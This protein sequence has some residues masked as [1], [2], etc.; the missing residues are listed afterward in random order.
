M[1]FLEKL[2]PLPRWKHS[3]PS[4]RVAA[5]YEF[6]SADTEALHAVAREDADAR[7]RRASVSRLTEVSVLVEI[8]GSD[9]DEDVRAEAIR[10]LAGQAAEADGAGAALPILQSLVVLGRNREVVAIARSAA[11]VDIRA[12]AT[13]LLQDA[14]S[15]GSVSRHAEDTATRLRALAKI[16]SDDELV[17]VACKCDHTDAA[18]AA[19]ERLSDQEAVSAVSQR[20]RNKVALRR[21]RTRLREME[22]AARP[23]PSEPAVQMLLADRQRA[24][25]ITRRASVLVTV[26]LPD[27]AAAQLSE[28]RLA[29][30]EMQADVVDVDP[31]LLRSF[32]A[33]CEAAGEA[34]AER[35]RDQAAALDRTR[36]L[37]TEQSDRLAICEEI[38]RLAGPESM[39]RVAE[40]KAKW[41]MLP[42]MPSDYAASL[43]LRFQDVCREQDARER[44][45][46]LAE[47]A[48]SRLETLASELEHLSSSEQPVDETVVRWR[49]LRRD[50]ETLREF[51]DANPAAGERLTRAIEILE[52]R[53]HEFQQQ[54]AK[55]EQQNIRRLQ[56]VCRRAETL[57]QADLLT[58]KAGDRA[59]REIREA[60]DQRVP[61]PSKKVRQE[62][63]SLLEAARTK[64]APRVQELRDSDDWQRFG[65]LQVQEELCAKMEAL[66]T[67][68]DL[69]TCART[70]RELQ[71]RWKLVAAVPRAQGEVLWRRFK[72]AQDIVF[73]RCEAYFAGQVV[74]RASNLAL[75]EELVAKVKALADSTDWVKTAQEIQRVQAEWKT[76]G[77]VPRGK[78]RA[79]WE[80][81]RGA[82]DR[83]FTSRQENLKRRKD[84]W[85]S[86][87]ERKEALC[88]QVEALADSSDWE[89]SA[90]A[91]KRLQSEWK[92]VGFVRKAKSDLVWN[93]FR[94]ACDRFFDRYKHR[95]QVDLQVR[96]TEYETIVGDMEGLLPT[97]GVEPE[98]PEGLYALVQTARAKWQ[99]APEVPRS[100]LDGLFARFQQS[101]SGLV[102]AWPAAFAGTDL[103]PATTLARMEK[104]VVRVEKLTPSADVRPSAM[105]PAELLAK[106]WRERLAANTISGGKPGES[107]DSRWRAA[108]QEVRSAQQQWLRLGPVPSEAVAP[109]VDRFQRACRKFFDQRRR[110]T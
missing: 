101:L 3:D 76:V 99:Q 87:L 67:L 4:V 13:D 43:T 35:A 54:R 62:L 17:A 68:E 94:T 39:D 22:E 58:L 29:W 70:M 81:F 23:A 80:R 11:V 38:T 95:D 37:A 102:A 55:A 84:E 79:I 27:E 40:L 103:D 5:V 52:E 63:Y 90:A 75:K 106:Q 65:N 21:A 108:E 89:L 8:A 64:L 2:R 41:D 59:L 96:V 19:L 72:A 24:Q 69:E 28:V 104:L 73:G 51:S 71:A 10:V 107:D 82:C 100:V 1:G 12:A 18:V 36:A 15:L 47:A 85:T 53:E 49:G 91:I 50:A 78:E 42:R 33:A 83:F 86:N 57:A 45:R 60:L 44:R 48:S 31:V 26:A 93:R 66:L 88:S 109:L 92:T 25:E 34:I 7:V 77:A 14:R 97:A 6:G 16:E 74:A 20:A 110:A 98:A 105:S 30:A 32:D 9:P 56:H 61:L 46:M